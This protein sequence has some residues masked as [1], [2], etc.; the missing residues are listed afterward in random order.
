MKAGTNV[1]RN[2]V[3]GLISLVLVGFFIPTEGTARVFN[4]EICAPDS[5][6]RGD[7]LESNAKLPGTQTSKY[8][9]D[10]QGNG[11][12]VL[13]QRPGGGIGPDTILFRAFTDGSPADKVSMQGDGNLVI[14]GGPTVLKD[15]E[16]TVQATDPP[17]IICNTFLTIDSDGILR[18]GRNISILWDTNPSVYQQKLNCHGW[19]TNC[20]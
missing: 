15:T 12:L 16:I 4:D 19:R 18:I 14:Y 5:M 17:N 2:T 8:H 3:V 7:R 11:D 1:I 6:F 9:L 10:F 20:R 13:Y